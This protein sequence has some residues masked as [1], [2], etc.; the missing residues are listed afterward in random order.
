MDPSRSGANY[1]APEED[2]IVETLRSSGAPTCPR[3]GGTM[4]E[5]DVPPREGVAYVRRRIWLVCEGCRRSFVVDRRRVER[6]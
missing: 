3:C 1:S 6:A 2:T 4:V 5:R